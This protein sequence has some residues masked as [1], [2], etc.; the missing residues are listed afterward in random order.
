MFA[1]CTLIDK[2]KYRDLFGIT[3]NVVESLYTE[4]ESYGL[5]GG[6][7]QYTDD[8]HFRVQPFGRL[9]NV[10]IDEVVPDS[11]YEK[12]RDALK[13]HY[14]GDRRVNDV[15]ICNGGTIM[16]DCRN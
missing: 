4:Y 12:V 13:A 8:Q 1:G 15:Y 14:E 5:A 3:D 11:E 7:A 9:V 2:W 16:I 10:K 6:E